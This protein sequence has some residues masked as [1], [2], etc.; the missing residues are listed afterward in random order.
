MEVVTPDQ[1]WKARLPIGQ[2]ESWPDGENSG[3]LF[4][5]QKGIKPKPHY[6]IVFEVSVVD[7]KVKD[8]SQLW[9]GSL[10][11]LNGRV[12]APRGEKILLDRWLDWRPIPEIEGPH[13]D[14]PKLLGL[15]EHL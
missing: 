15:P 9:M 12:L 4:L 11:D 14:D 6:G 5:L 1:V 2:P 7:G 3:K 13:T 10:Y 8:T